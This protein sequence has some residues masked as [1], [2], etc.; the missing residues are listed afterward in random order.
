MVGSYEL[1]TTPLGAASASA[2][3]PP[4]A[5]SSIAV[6][7]AHYK[8]M[9]SSMCRLLRQ[10]TAFTFRLGPFPDSTDGVT[11]ETGL[12][13]SQADIQ[14]SK[15]GGA[16]AQTSAASPVTTHDSE[17][18]YQCPLTATDTNTLGSLTV[19][20]VKAGALSSWEHF[21]VV[22]ANVFDSLV[23]GSDTLDVQVT[24]MGTAVLTAAA[25]AA[26]AAE[27]IRDKVAERT[28]LRGTVGAAS[29]TTSI[30]TSAMTPATSVADQ[31]KGRIVL[32]DHNTTTAALRG[33]A[34]D[35]TA[36]SASATPVLTVTALTNA[37]ASGDTFTIV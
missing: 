29:T 12:T 11:P 9:E 32:F 31:L 27:E 8:R 33:Q 6:V 23:A 24:G 7:A 19:R 14:I 34:T 3:A 26:D 21:L 4:P 20:V 15:N 17:G 10:S 25:L 1:G 28:T 5:P 16:F 22:P 18:W 2:G 36:S 13:I 37:P 30:V 35:I